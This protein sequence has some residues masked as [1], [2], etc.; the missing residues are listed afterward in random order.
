V[1]QEYVVVAGGSPLHPNVLAQLADDR[2]VI[3]AD[4]GLDHARAAGLA[5]D[6]VVGDLDSVSPDALAAAER[7]GVPIERHPAAKEAIDTELAIDAALAHGADRITLVA[8][9]GDRIDHVLAGLL[10][11][12]HPMLAGVDVQAWYGTAWLRGLQGPA[13]TPIEGPPGADVSLVPVGGTAE[14]VV[15]AGLLYPL[16][17]E[18]LVPASTRGLS[19]EIVTSPAC[20]SLERGAVLVIV[21]YAL[22]GAS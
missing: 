17:H 22:G 14:G 10:L 15:T 21:P 4:S 18:P 6:L 20:V 19:N 12:T 5:V 13:E 8:G 11:L 7:G 2:F 3:A 1:S 9:G 16:H